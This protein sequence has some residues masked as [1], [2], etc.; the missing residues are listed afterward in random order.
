MSFASKK[1]FCLHHKMAGT[2]LFPENKGKN[3]PGL[4][5]HD[6]VA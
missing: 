4:L 1:T 5:P 6:W 2:P 3:A